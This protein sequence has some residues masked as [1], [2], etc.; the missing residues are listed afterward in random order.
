MAFITQL[1]LMNKYLLSLHLNAFLALFPT[2]STH[3]THLCTSQFYLQHCLLVGS[4]NTVGNSIAPCF[5][6][7]LFATSLTFMV[8]C[9]SPEDLSTRQPINRPNVICFPRSSWWLYQFCRSLG[10]HQ[11]KV[12]SCSSHWNQP[13]QRRTDYNRNKYRSIEKL[14]GNVL[15]H[16]SWDSNAAFAAA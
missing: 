4:K 10:R 3:K 16:Q 13:M 5:T 8:M 14:S 2:D 1:C 9:W 11:V 12:N 6:W 7:N 15:K